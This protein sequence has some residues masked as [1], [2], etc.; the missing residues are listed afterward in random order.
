[1]LSIRRKVGERLDRLL[2]SVEKKRTG[3]QNLAVFVDGKAEEIED[4]LLELA[5]DKSR[6]GD[7]LEIATRTL[8]EGTAIKVDAAIYRYVMRTV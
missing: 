6:W 8:G 5:A 2:W 1:M 7:V 3:G 4:G